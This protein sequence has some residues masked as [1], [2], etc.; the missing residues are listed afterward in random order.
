MKIVIAGAGEIGLH[1]AQLLVKEMQDITIID[2]DRE[3]LRYISNNLD[4]A[5]I[6]GDSSSYSTLEKIDAGNADLLISL[7]SHE[8]INLITSI[9]GK[10]LGSKRTIARVSN[11]EYTSS[12]K[13]K[14]LKDL[15]IDQVISLE[16]L[17]AKE[18]SRLLKDFTITDLFYFDDHKLDFIGIKIGQE[19]DRKTLEEMKLFEDKY[20]RCLAILRKGITFVPSSDEKLCVNDHVYYITLPKGEKNILKSL[21]KNPRKIKT[22][23]ILGA[24]KIGIQ[25]AKILEKK[26]SIKII[27]CRKKK[28]LELID[29]LPNTLFIHGD[30][31]DVKLLEEENI[32]ETDALIAVTPNSEINIISSLI[33]NKYNLQKSISLVENNSY[34]QL[35][36]DIDSSSMLN[37]IMINKKIIAANFIFRYIRKGDIVSLISIPGTDIEVLELIVHNKSF[38]ANKKLGDIENLKGSKIGGVIRDD[39]AYIP[40]K[41]FLFKDKDRVML[42]SKVEYTHEVEKLFYE[43]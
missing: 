31:R 18:I 36:Q 43:I 12:K 25:T 28:I 9:I 1:L 38:I 22:I 16:R 17:A 26:F 39:K 27:E 15:G 29:E 8:S 14:E 2:K 35:S 20:F 34:I 37:N 30:A 10:K 5:T 4:V 3:R 42:L 41:N 13:K 40:N 7:T 21:H 24:S 11:I 33:A 23:M 19:A 32:S 6:L